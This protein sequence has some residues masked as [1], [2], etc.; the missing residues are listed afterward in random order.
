[1]SQNCNFDFDTVCT[2]CLYIWVKVYQSIGIIY[3]IFIGILI[4]FSM[5]FLKI[6]ADIGSPNLLIAV[7]A[8]KITDMKPSLMSIGR[9]P[10]ATGA[11]SDSIFL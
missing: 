4:V 8:H 11:H 3:S 1:M 6:I 2:P 10:A 7:T 9:L 5:F